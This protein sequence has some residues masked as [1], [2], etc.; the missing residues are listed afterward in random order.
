MDEPMLI[1]AKVVSDSSSDPLGLGRIQVYIPL[2]HGDES[3]DT[4]KYPWADCLLLN[5]G[6][7]SAE[8]PPKGS[9]VLVGFEGNDYDKPVVF[10]IYGSDTAHLESYASQQ[11]IE[12]MYAGGTLAEIA[13]SI[14]F[15]QEGSYTSVNWNDNGAISIG[16]VQWH[17]NRARNLMIKIKNENNTNYT[18]ICNKYGG[19]LYSYTSESVSWASLRNWSA[20]CPSGKALVEILGTDESKKVQDNQAIEDVSGYIDQIKAKGV[21][22]PAC[23]IY[24]ADIYNQGPAYALKIAQNCKAKNY[25]LDKMHN[26]LAN[27]EPGTYKYINDS[28]YGMPRRERVYKAIK[29]VEAEGKLTPVA[30]SGASGDTGTGLVGW[31]TP[32]V[33]KV[34]SYFGTRSLG[35]HPGIDIGCPIGTKIYAAH[36]GVIHHKICYGYNKYGATVSVNGKG[37]GSLG[38]MAWIDG[39]SFGYSTMYG[40]MQAECT[41]PDGTTIK[42]GTFIGYTGNTGNSTGPHLHW[43]VY[44]RSSYTAY[45]NAGEVDPLSV[46][47]KP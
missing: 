4:S 14:I 17:G 31:P 5:V 21:E 44:K 7:S 37:T 30:L 29:Q 45:Q 19:D 38:C 28:K 11:G 18:N 10:G 25:N 39:G 33:G 34:T 6:S 32:D 43:G 26:A 12:G 22:D 35:Y 2:L 46:T 8:K 15:S 9:I 27:G 36:D 3:S 16:K 23:L 47:K 41:I 24:L 13:A 20:S 1:K 42:R 40:H